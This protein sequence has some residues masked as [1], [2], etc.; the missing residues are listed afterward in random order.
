MNKTFVQINEVN[1]VSSRMKDNQI[2]SGWIKDGMN[3][4]EIQARFVQ[5]I[6]IHRTSSAKFILFM[7]TKNL[8]LS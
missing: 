4:Q 6:K 1:G 5:F 3:Q 8:I 7:Q 2:Q